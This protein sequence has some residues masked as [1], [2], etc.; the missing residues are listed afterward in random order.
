ME[1]WKYIILVVVVLVGGVGGIFFGANRKTFLP[2][3][4]SFTGAYILGITAMSLLPSVYMGASAKIG[5]W[6]LVGFLLQISFEYLSKG[7]EHGHIHSH[8]HE[9]QMVYVVQVLIGLSLHAFLEGLPI[10]GFEEVGHHHHEENLF[11]AIIV[12][13]APAAFALTVLLVTNGLNR[14]NAMMILLGFAMMT[15]FGAWLGSHWQADAHVMRIF[16]AILI[17]AF[18]HISTLILFE[19]DKDSGHHHQ[20]SIT[21]MLIILFGFFLA[22]IVS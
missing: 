4:L 5:I 13:K 12:H 2:Y 18:F 22:Y 14:V 11:W 17:G 10:S 6:M 21:K 9:K 19:N 7:V 20:F 8:H 3:A 1:I 15:P 16:L